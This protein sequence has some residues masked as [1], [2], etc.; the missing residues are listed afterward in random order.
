M[1]QK[2]SVRKNLR[3]SNK[4]NKILKKGGV[5][6]IGILTQNFE[7]NPNACYLDSLFFPLFYLHV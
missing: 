2:K 3:K 6:R 5:P 4:K 1:V 7:V